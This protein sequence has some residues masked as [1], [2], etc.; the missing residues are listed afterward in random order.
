[1]GSSQLGHVPPMPTRRMKVEQSAALLAEGPRPAV[2]AFVD[3]DRPAGPGGGDGD[4]WLVA[5]AAAAVGG[6]AAGVAAE[7]S[8]A[9]RGEGVLADGAGHRDAIVTRREISGHG[10]LTAR[11]VAS[12]RARWDRIR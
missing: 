4:G 3:G 6:G 2:V 9:V 10:A 12:A 7:A 5:V 8:P 1:M 11:R